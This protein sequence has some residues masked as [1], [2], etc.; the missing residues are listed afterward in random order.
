MFD[1]VLREDCDGIVYLILNCLEKL[2]VLMVVFFKEF[3]G[4]VE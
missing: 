4:Y 3:D 2:N 1:L